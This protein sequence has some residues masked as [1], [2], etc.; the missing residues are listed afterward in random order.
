MLS[1]QFEKYIFTIYPL[2]T[3]TIILLKDD[4]SEINMTGK[5]IA[6]ES[7]KKYKF[8]NPDVPSS[9]SSLAECKII[10]LIGTQHFLP[11]G[12]ISW[13]KHIL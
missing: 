11:R 1:N 7:D 12:A 3:D 10:I 4:G 9:Y 13:S 8:R 5:G 6:W 2:F